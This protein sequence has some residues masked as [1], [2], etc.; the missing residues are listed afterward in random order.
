MT[1]TS[2]VVIVYLF[3]LDG[4]CSSLEVETRQSK[5]QTTFYATG[6]VNFKQS[7]EYLTPG[8]G[9]NQTYPGGETQV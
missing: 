5:L 4:E 8:Y 9:V 3:N 6:S 1:L 2:L 7:G